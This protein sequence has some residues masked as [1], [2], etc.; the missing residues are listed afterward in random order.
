MDWS[1]SRLDGFRQCKRRY[2][3]RGIDDER[4]E[5]MPQL[6]SG[7]LLH[8]MIEEYGRHCHTEK[9]DMDRN[10]AE[11]I[12][13]RAEDPRVQVQFMRF[14]ERT[15][16]N[17]DGLLAG[18][19]GRVFEVWW[20]APL[21]GNL[22]QF[23]A[24]IDWCSLQEGLLLVQDW[25]SGFVYPTSQ[26]DLPTLQLQRYA[27]LMMQQVFAPKIEALHVRQEWVGSGAAWSW[28]L[29]LHQV[30]DIEEHLMDEVRGVI[31]YQQQHGDEEWP[32]E[33]GTYC[34]GCMY[35]ETCSKACRVPSPTTAQDL[36]DGVALFAAGA[37]KLRKELKVWVSER[38]PFTDREG[39]VHGPV[40]EAGR[41]VPRKGK[42][43][44]LYHVL[45]GAK[46]DAEK[47][48]VGGD[49]D[50]LAPDERFGSLLKQNPDRK[51]WRVRRVMNYGDEE[52][53][54]EEDDDTNGADDTLDRK[55]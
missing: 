53:T 8:A 27:W 30:L 43:L 14:V 40:T 25:K 24:R 36:A 50:S 20:E 5:P 44:D 39:L 28:E 21:P 34:L 52:K 6:E 13:G 33:P 15:L 3:L 22:G 47:I 49:F 46:L 1:H 45:E 54:S 17:F 51:P 12:A 29:G 23:R 10:H 38:G 7:K 31:A 11:V 35:R 41:W 37:C 9:R 18:P 4:E 19:E 26:P 42:L 16:W 55:E 32:R 48:I 2:Q